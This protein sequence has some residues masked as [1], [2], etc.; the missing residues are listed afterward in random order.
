MC[1]YITREPRLYVFTFDVYVYTLT[2]LPKYEWLEMC[3]DVLYSKELTITTMRNI[4]MVERYSSGLFWSE[5]VNEPVAAT[6]RDLRH[7]RIL[8][9]FL[10]NKFY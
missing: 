1:F 2:R 4:V 10:G 6:N 5:N 8:I 7:I 3:N 9:K